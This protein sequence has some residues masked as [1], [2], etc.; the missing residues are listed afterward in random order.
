MNSKK[1]EIG[2]EFNYTPKYP[3]QTLQKAI[4]ILMYIKENGSTDGLTIAELSEKLDMGKSVVH[5]ILDT[6]YSYRFVEKTDKNGAYRLGWGLYEIAQTI[7]LHHSLSED[8]YRKTMEQ[9]CNQFQETVNLGIY[10][11]G[12]VVIIC[13]VEPDRRVRSNIEV[14]EREP[15]YATALGKQFLSG[16]TKVIVRIYFETVQLKKLTENT[17][18]DLDKMYEELKKVRMNGVS[19]DNQEY[20]EDLI[21]TAAPIYNYENKIVAALSISVPESRYTEKISKEIVNSLKE[22]AMEISEFLGY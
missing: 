2:M 21:C 5:R 7:P 13:K 18:V 12:E 6:L 4:E 15:L 8:I 1:R 10:N 16:F 11:N 14:G 17:I 9:L 22:A 20:S 3:V 19:I